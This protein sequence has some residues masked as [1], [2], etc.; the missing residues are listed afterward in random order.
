MKTNVLEY[1]EDAAL[2]FPNKVALQ[3][4]ENSILYSDLILRAKAIGTKLAELNERNRPVV[5]FID[6]DIES[7]EM[8]MGIVYSGNF[9]VPVD[10]KLPLERINSI[11][12]T[13]NPIS[14]ITK[15]RY[16]WETELKIE[17]SII[18]FQDAIKS[19]IDEV[20]LMEIRAT[21]IDTDPLYSI[22]T[23]GSTGVPKGVLIS[24]RGV[25]DLVEAFQGAFD[26]KDDDIFGNQAPFDFDVSTKDIYNSF[27]NGATV[28]IIPQRM[29]SFPVDLIK[30]L[31]ERKVSV[32]IWAVSALNIVANI[33]AMKRI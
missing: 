32:I 9:Y 12:A 25:I 28:D 15:E 11:I 2:R 20:V 29:F 4:T 19:K 3:D 16:E 24:H 21:A 7:I 10:P 30:H 27:K 31:N 5:V 23:S 22:F 26:F 8:F 13:L 1:L 17:A 14:I 6:R 33:R 18:N